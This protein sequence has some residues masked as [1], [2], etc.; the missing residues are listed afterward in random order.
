MKTEQEI[1]DK[2]EEIRDALENGDIEFKEY[3][4]EWKYVEVALAWVIYDTTQSEEIPK[5]TPKQKR[6]YKNQKV[7]YGKGHPKPKSNHRLRKKQFTDEEQR[8]KRNAYQRV[9]NKRKRIEAKKLLH[10]VASNIHTSNP[11]KELP[12]TNPIM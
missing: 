8:L 4:K 10:K 1:K 3:Y 11:R 6:H 9:Y 2:M 12:P 7:H 5:L